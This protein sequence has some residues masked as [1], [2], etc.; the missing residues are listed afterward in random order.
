MDAYLPKWHSLLFSCANKIAS[1][2]IDSFHWE[3][4]LQERN[5]TKL[6]EQFLF[7][8]N[9]SGKKVIKLWTLFVATLAPPASTTLRFFL[10]LKAPAGNNWRK[11]PLINIFGRRRKLIHQF[12][13]WVI[14]KCPTRWSLLFIFG[15]LYWSSMF[16]IPDNKEV[17][18]SAMLILDGCSTVVL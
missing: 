14:V 15:Y 4:L 7:R 11:S 10:L 6:N 13:C 1:P 3:T 17:Y 8:A 12:W 18:Y 5:K 9:P 2:S 16:H